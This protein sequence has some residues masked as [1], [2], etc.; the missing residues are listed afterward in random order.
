M[1]LLAQRVTTI[2]SAVSVVVIDAAQ[3]DRWLIQA[4]ERPPCAPLSGQLFNPRDIARTH[5]GATDV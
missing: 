5:F 2:E 4:D 1:K 3:Q